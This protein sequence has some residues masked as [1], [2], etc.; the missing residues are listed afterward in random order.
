MITLI[1]FKKILDL[2][3]SGLRSGPKNEKI[4]WHKLPVNKDVI[5]QKLE[6]I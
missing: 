3:L 4:C 5:L 6:F 1:V 2:D